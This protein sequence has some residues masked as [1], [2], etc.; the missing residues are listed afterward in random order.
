MEG[1]DSIDLAQYTDTWWGL[2]IA[3]VNL[4]VP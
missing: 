2:V 1:M 3:V 4:R